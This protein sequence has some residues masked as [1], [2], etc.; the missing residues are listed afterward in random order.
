MKKLFQCARFN[1]KAVTV[2]SWLSLLVLA[3]CS[4]SVSTN[5]GGAVSPQTT[6]TAITIDNAGVIPVFGNSATSTV[7]Y[8]HNN[9]AT[10][11]SG[12]SYSVV[13]NEGSNNAGSVDGVQ[14]SAIAAGQS[15]A[16][17]IITPSLPN[18]QNQGSMLIKASYVLAEK[19]QS[20]SQL[21]NYAAVDGA[22]NKVAAG[23][24]FKS[25]ATIS[26]YGNS[27]GYATL[28][29]Y[30]SGA[31]QVYTITGL[32]ASQ[33][34]L[35]FNMGLKN[36]TLSANAVQAVE[37]S[38]PIL[39]SSI[40]SALTV[41]SILAPSSSKSSNSNLHNLISDNSLQSGQFSDSVSLAVEPVTSGAILTSGFV[42]LINTVSATS[43]SL[44]IRNA[45]NQTAQVGSAT[46]GSGIS[47]L[48]GCSN[49]SLAPS[50]TCT[51]NF[52]V[53]ESGGSA[54]ITVPYTGGSASSVVANVTWFNGVGAA[55]VSMS[56][57]DNPLSFSA[58]IGATTR[59]TITNIGGYSL[60]NLSIPAPVVFGGSA[61]ATLVNNNCA[62]IESLP[63][64][65]SCSYDVSVADSMT[66][67]DQQIN[68]GFSGNY[69][70]SNGVTNYSRI[71][72]LTYSSTS[73]GAIIVL[74]PLSAMSISGDNL[75][76]A[77]QEL[78]ISNNG[79]ATADLTSLGLINNPAYLTTNN[80]NCGSSL[81]AESS[82]TVQIKLGPV[83]SDLESSGVANYV[84][85][86]A[87]IGQTPAGIEST[88]VA[89]SV[90]PNLPNITMVASVTGCAS[91]NGITT[92]CMDNPT[93]TG[94]SSSSIQV[95][96]TFTNSSSVTAATTISLP[97]SSSSLF[98]VSGYSLFSNSCT[99]GAAINNGSCTIIY[100]LPSSAATTAFQS[101]LSRSDFAYN[102]TYGASG[103]VSAS[104]TS[105]LA[106]TID[107]VMP[108]LAIGSISA[109]AQGGQSTAAINWGNL[110]QA[111]VPTTI[112]SATA[113]DGSTAVI[114][115]SSA[116]PATCGSVASNVASCTSVIT[117]T[118]STPTGT[119]YLL[120][121]SAAGGLS[122]T[123]SPFKV[124][125]SNNIIFVTSGTWNGNLG[126]FAGANTKCNAD[127][128]KPS[129]SDAG[130][131]KTYKALLNGN[132]ATTT[133]VTY[134]KTGGVTPIA[135]ATGGNLVGSASL[136]NA[137]G[138]GA[139]WTGAS[140]SCTLWT[141][142]SN[143]GN[144][145]VGSSTSTTSTWWSISTASCNGSRRLY[146]VAQ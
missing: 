1:C 79:A 142:N 47:N 145:S 42:P 64:G 99:N 69:A 53:T 59:V 81:A 113:S 31:N 87:A 121:A 92:T 7:I 38:S 77:T 95:V 24:K 85:N 51:I 130:A 12:I 111:A 22:S 65:I 43:G 18:Q 15:C 10:T 127:E 25:G 78:T 45:G 112:T 50:E 86:Y 56:I 146:C 144:G 33:P 37:V 118:D 62:S 101:S 138:I 40:S 116:T 34:S 83:S 70:G 94:G 8:V 11:V 16:L 93:A 4:N 54:N 75:E 139:V 52:N 109:I 129:G 9:S 72:P 17:K 71:M 100:T 49:T 3:A 80:G 32:S 58:T 107:V 68:L 63:I 60:T 119:G 126:G 106:T 96:L 105:N 14:C 76:S 120:K 91:G 90:A 30:A 57:A 66:D 135:T 74:S 20:F 23:V 19:S 73:Y 140:L 26:G 28:Y 98:T 27:T 35:K 123:P 108:T 46:A 61:T 103:E 132:N 128:S 39:G 136:S 115:L 84:V 124:V 110:Y 5:S 6:A 41:Q 125:L 134:Y 117:T 141:T 143:S 122:A 29:L 89:W 44:L 21:I 97:E 131:G 36:I 102:Y 137:I 88:S 114:G 133:G 13:N 2:V 82:C 48:S 104:G 55:L 67:L